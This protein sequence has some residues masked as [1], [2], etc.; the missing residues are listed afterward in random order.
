MAI[1]NMSAP[2][3]FFESADKEAQR[4]GISFSAFVRLLMTQYFD[5][6][7]FERRREEPTVAKEG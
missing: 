7:K 2:P 3:E 6:I 1:R 5:G 4:L